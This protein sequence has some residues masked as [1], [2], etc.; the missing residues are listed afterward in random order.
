MWVPVLLQYLFRTELISQGSIF[1]VTGQ[2]LMLACTQLMEPGSVFGRHNGQSRLCERH[3][4][5][6][7]GGGQKLM[8]GSQ[9]YCKVFPHNLFYMGPYLT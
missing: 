3:G 8:C 6:G 7:G 9:F 4:G 1:N 2:L 5:W